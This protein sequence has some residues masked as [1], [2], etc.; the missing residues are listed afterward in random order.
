MFCDSDWTNDKI[1]RRS[2]SGYVVL[3]AGGAVSWS[4]KKQRTTALST[5]EAEYFSMC[6]AAKEVLWFR[7]FFSKKYLINSF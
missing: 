5:I 3:L 1:D 6:H 2:F 4:S 7:N